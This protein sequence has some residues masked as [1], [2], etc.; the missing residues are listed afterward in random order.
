MID[1]AKAHYR[2]VGRCVYCGSIEGLSSEHIIPHALYPKSAR[3][4]AVLPRASCASHRRVTGEFER[5]VLRE[6]FGGV[7]KWLGTKSR[8]RHSKAPKSVPALLRGVAGE[9]AAEI[10]FDQSPILVNFPIFARPAVLAQ[11]ARHG[12]VLTG[13]ATYS[14]GPHPKDVVNSL[15]ATDIRLTQSFQPTQFARMLAKIA[16]CYAYATGDIR[17]IQEGESVV[18]AAIRGERDDI[19]HWVG[20]FE[21]PLTRGEGLHR[22]GLHDFSGGFLIGEVQLFADAGTPRYGV[23]LGRLR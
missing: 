7:R 16:Y 20:T 10:P 17:R 21:D 14:F 12:L 8:S 3:G 1:L 15:G 13:Y 9:W 23:V 11:P 2:S 22:I 6:L 19:G 18:L 5:H 4:A